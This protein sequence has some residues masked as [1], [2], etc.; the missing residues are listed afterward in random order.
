MHLGGGCSW[1]SGLAHYRGS[2]ESSPSE[3][4]KLLQHLGVGY[5]LE[6]MCNYSPLW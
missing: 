4:P 5:W 2:L 6:P 3:H 1:G